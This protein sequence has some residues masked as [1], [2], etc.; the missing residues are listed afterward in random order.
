MKTECDAAGVS[1]ARAKAAK[2][3]RHVRQR[4]EKKGRKKGAQDKSGND[5]EREGKDEDLKGREKQEC[6]RQSARKRKDRDGARNKETQAG[7]KAGK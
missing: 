6:G 2:S 4:K 3:F 5:G 7:N 1:V